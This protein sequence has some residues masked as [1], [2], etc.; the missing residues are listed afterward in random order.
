MRPH[1]MTLL[2]RVDLARV[3]TEKMTAL[4]ILPKGQYEL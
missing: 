1:R 2:Q 3:T 4:A